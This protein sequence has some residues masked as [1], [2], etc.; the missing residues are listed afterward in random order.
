[1]E[2]EGMSSSVEECRLVNMEGVLKLGSHYLLITVMKTE[3]HRRMLNLVGSFSE[4][5]DIG[6]A[7]S[8]LPWTPY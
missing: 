5:Q 2:G 8:I 4:E 7:E 3:N 1:M 6:A